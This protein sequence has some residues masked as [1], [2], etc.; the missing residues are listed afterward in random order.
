M[1]TTR[2]S[3]PSE[4]GH[5]RTPHHFQR[6]NGRL[7]FRLTDKRLDS[8]MLRT[9]HC[10]VILCVNV[11]IF[12]FSLSVLDGNWRIIEMKE[13]RGPSG[14]LINTKSD[15]S[16]F[17]AHESNSG[18]LIRIPTSLSNGVFITFGFWN[19]TVHRLPAFLFQGGVRSK[20]WFLTF[21]VTIGKVFQWPLPW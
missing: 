20:I 11:G 19:A 2:W 9:E 10:A 18:G 15:V 3:K 16:V 8:P 14:S 13:T 4:E 21:S 1:G 12:A 7:A 6:W 17:D 5:G